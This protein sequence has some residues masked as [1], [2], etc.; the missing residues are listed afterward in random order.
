MNFWKD[1]QYHSFKVLIIVV[2][3][4][5]VGA[6]SIGAMRGFDLSGRV[7]EKESINT[8]KLFG[9]QTA[10]GPQEVFLLGGSN[11]E[12]FMNDVWRSSQG[13]LTTWSN[14]SPNDP[15]TTEKWEPFGTHTAAYWQNKIWLMGSIYGNG[16]DKIWYS[17]DGINWEYYIVNGLPDM[18]N[19]GVRRMLVYQNKLWLFFTTTQQSGG[20]FPEA[21]GLFSSIDGYN[22]QNINFSSESE[23]CVNRV[24]G[25]VIVFQ[26][27]MYI[28]GGSK[29]GGSVLDNA[30]DDGGSYDQM[31]IDSQPPAPAVCSSNDGENWTII[32]QNTDFQ[33]IINGKTLSSH[34]LFVLGDK[35]YVFGGKINDDNPGLDGP[36]TGHFLS[37]SLDG[38]TWTTSVNPPL[39]GHNNP[40]LRKNMR[41]FTLGSKVYILGGNEVAPGGF[42]NGWGDVYQDI[43][44]Y[45]GGPALNP[46]S[47]I[48]VIPNNS[49]SPFGP[50][51]V[52][53]IIVKPGSEIP[54]APNNGEFG[55]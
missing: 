36:S 7:Y 39:I 6:F 21:T 54:Q 15:D 11:G 32:A 2:A 26:N 52:H 35:L 41:A 53:A 20:D 48:T 28:I 55:Q 33:N 31:G 3:V 18:D 27:K 23:S 24:S 14:I 16:A 47:W 40:L 4:F 46:S 1:P 34:A 38:I 49:T 45:S 9:P 37:S 25:E 51:T 8:P 10:T 12:D 44:Q 13:S 30:T 5:G 19:P 50:H 42:G 17:S 29:T 22:W 43:I